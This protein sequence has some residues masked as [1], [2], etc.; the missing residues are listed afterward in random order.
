MA[1]PIILV[2]HDA[3]GKSG[4]ALIPARQAAAKLNATITILHVSDAPLPIALLQ[5]KLKLSDEEVRGC[6][7]ESA[8]GADPAAVIIDWARKS[9]AR[10]IVMCAHGERES[11]GSV[12]SNVI[13]NAPCPVLV[14]RPDTVLNRFSDERWLRRIL[15]P[16][17]ASPISAEACQMAARLAK[18]EGARLDILH[19]ATAGEPLPEEPGSLPLGPYIDH[20]GYDLKIWS[21][22]FLDRFFRLREDTP[23]DLQPSLHISRGSAADEIIKFA[24]RE[25]SDLIVIAWQGCFD[26]G[27]AKVIR[28]LLVRAPCPLLS[29]VA[30]KTGEQAAANTKATA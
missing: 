17:D 11:I 6:V 2:P 13:C 10:L 1:A 14:V 16:L 9:S 23:D 26:D 27:R 5:Q 8:V 25:S 7:L 21:E 30:K 18:H 4:L 29:L 20:R 12:T 22:E 28:E 24:S 19:I 3:T 15:V